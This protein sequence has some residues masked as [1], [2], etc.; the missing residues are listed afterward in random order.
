MPVISWN[1]I[2]QNAI[3]F[4]RDWRDAHY[5]RGEAQTFWNDSIKQTY[6]RIDLFWRGTPPSANLD[7]KDG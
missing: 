5:E 1:E 4:S 2:R 7:G 6:H 3:Q